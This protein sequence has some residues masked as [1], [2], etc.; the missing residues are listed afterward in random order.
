MDK[1]VLS[2]GLRRATVCIS[3]VPRRCIRPIQARRSLIEDTAIKGDSSVKRVRLIICGS[4]A[5]DGRSGGR[6]RG[7]GATGVCAYTHA[8]GQYNFTRRATL[9]AEAILKL[10]LKLNGQTAARAAGLPV[11][12]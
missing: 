9:G 11:P 12:L 1:S 5:H 2:P 6:R 4:L 3:P 8:Y 10:N 7:G